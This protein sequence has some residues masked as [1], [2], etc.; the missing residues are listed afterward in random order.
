MCNCKKQNGKT[1]VNFLTLAPGSTEDSATYQLTMTHFCCGNRKVCSREELPISA[2][3]RFQVLGLPD[4][5]G[6]GTYSCNVLITGQCTYMPYVDPYNCGC[7]CNQ[8]PETDNIYTILPVPCPSNTVPVLTP[9][10]AT[11]WPANVPSCCLLTNQIGIKC[12]FNVS[13]PQS[14]TSGN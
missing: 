2:D 13:T 7:N 4:D 5:M 1:I 6:N 10:I 8:C 3:L 11:A 14:T 12:S 9:G